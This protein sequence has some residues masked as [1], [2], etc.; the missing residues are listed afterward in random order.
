MP[1]VLRLPEDYFNLLKAV[2][3]RIRAVDPDIPVIG[4]CPTP[5][6]VR[7]G[8][9]DKLVQLGGLDYCDMISIHTY[10]YGMKGF[11]RTPEAWL[12]WMVEVQ[13]MLREHNNG[14]D[15]PFCVTEMGWPT[16]VGERGTSPELSGSYLGRLYLLAR[17]LPSFKGLWWY[18]YQD[19]GWN[20]EHNENNFGIARP[21]LTPKPAYYVMAD[22]SGLIR[23]G[24]Y[25]DRL[26]TSD[27]HLWILRF[28]HAQED[29]WAVWSGD[30]QDRQVILK[31]EN[32]G[33][34]L[35]LQKLGHKPINRRWGHR[36]W[37]RNRD[38]EFNPHQLSVVI[39]HRPYLIKGDLSGMSVVDVILRASDLE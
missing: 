9:L 10:N 25:V 12:G 35:V 24:E 32:P 13:T 22:V 19:D 7:R 37:P 39:G 38:R 2:Y 16:H 5:G 6:G 18:D 21:D 29:I 23:H 17:T 1:G 33:Q 8:W 3:K 27:E 30:D 26:N 4:G 20:P 11:D 31:T 34:N 28:N 14:M 15:P 36:D